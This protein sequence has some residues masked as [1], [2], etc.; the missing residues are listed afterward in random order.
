MATEDSHKLANLIIQA[1]RCNLEQ[2]YRNYRKIKSQPE[3]L[4]INTEIQAI[5]ERK[6][7]E[8]C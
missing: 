2:V 3:N 8:K 4:A 6:L 7:Y 1:M 5:Y